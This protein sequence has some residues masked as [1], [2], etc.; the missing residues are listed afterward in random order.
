LKSVVLDSYALI[1]I[2]FDESG[3]EN[4]EELLSAAAE[5]DRPVYISAVNW[6]EVLYIVSRRE[7]RAG[8]EKVMEFGRGAPLE[9]VPAD[10]QLAGLAASYKAENKMSLADAFAAALAK[11]K[12]AEL[13]TGDPEFKCVEKEIKIRWLK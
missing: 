6:A 3:A 1:A 2:L 5:S 7:G 12:K 4:V 10:A 8:L 13:A 11:E 9:I